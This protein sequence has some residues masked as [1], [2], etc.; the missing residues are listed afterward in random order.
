MVISP[1][2][3]LVP[4]SKG[5][6]TGKPVGAGTG[7]PA[8][9]LDPDRSQ[10]VSAA[11]EAMSSTTSAAIQGLR[12]TSSAVRVLEPGARKNWKAQRVY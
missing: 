7:L 9:L 8:W 12:V 10:K 4:L 6:G 2:R 5:L 1:G 3:G 11:V